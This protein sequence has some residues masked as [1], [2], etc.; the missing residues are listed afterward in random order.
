MDEL[1]VSHSQEQ[2]L[3]DKEVMN[4]MQRKDEELLDH[5]LLDHISRHTDLPWYSETLHGASKAELVEFM[6]RSCTPEFLAKHKL[7]GKETAVNKY[8]KKVK[9]PVLQNVYEEILDDP[10]VLV[11]HVMVPG[12][13]HTE[14]DA[15]VANGDGDDHQSSEVWPSDERAM[16][17]SRTDA[18][19]FDL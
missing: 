14:P 13:G 4:H 5:M 8:V 17:P 11:G 1:A 3:L 15:D 16:Q 18:P 19:T 10:T 6:Q 7:A 2:K 9:L 12:A